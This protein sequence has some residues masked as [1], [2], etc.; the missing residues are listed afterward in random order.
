[1]KPNNKI[2]SWLV[3]YVYMTRGALG[4]LIYRKQPHH[5]LGHITDGKVPV[6]IIPGVLEKWSFMKKIADHISRHG[7]PVYIVPDLGFNLYSIPH[8]SQIVRK[9][10]QCNDLKNCIIVAHSKGGLIGKYMLIHHNNDN[11]IIGLISIATPYSGSAMAKLVPVDPIK[12]L[13]HDSVIIKDLLSHTEVNH[14]IV[15]LSPLYDNHIWAEQGSHL[16]GA[17]NIVVPVHGHHKI[18][19]DATVLARVL[20]FVE[21]ITSKHSGRG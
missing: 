4:S 15:S 19:Y 5:Y 16:H 10:L 1:M 21:T 18:V 3:D 9:V 7:H 17:E 14:Q 13:H 11:R 2:K 20:E 8:S 6:I 12:E